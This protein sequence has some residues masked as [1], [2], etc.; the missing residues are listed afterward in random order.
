VVRGGSEDKTMGSENVS[1][2][3]DANLVVAI[4]RWRIRSGL[5]RL[6]LPSTHAGR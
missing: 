1:G 4:A 6:R 2:M 5:R 3:T